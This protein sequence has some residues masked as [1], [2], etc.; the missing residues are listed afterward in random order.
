[1]KNIEPAVSSRSRGE[2][3]GV[4]SSRKKNL[5]LSEVTSLGRGYFCWG[6]GGTEHG[7][8]QYLITSH[9]NF[10]GHFTIYQVI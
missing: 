1:M 5:G 6:G 9:G 4:E 8:G 2:G 10:S 3:G 7:W